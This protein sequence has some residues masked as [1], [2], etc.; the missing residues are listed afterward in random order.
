M[1][2]IMIITEIYLKIFQNNY[3]VQSY[4]LLE[5]NKWIMMQSFQHN[6]FIVE[7]IA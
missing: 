2:I 3:Y 6:K 7:L 5:I 1:N 4:R